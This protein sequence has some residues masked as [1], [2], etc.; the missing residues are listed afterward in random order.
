[1]SPAE[2]LEWER[3]QPGRHQRLG[4]AVYAMA[5][6]S[7]RHNLLGARLLE[8]LGTALRGG[9]CRP[10][11]SDQ[12]IHVPATG[13]Y[14]Y[15]DGIV[16]CGPVHLHGDTRDVIDNPCVVVEILSK[17]T[18]QH[19]RGEKWEGYR[20]LASLADYVLVSQRLAR[21]EHFA[22]EQDGSWRYRVFG[23]GGRFVLA[24]GAE[25]V[26]DGLYDGIFKIPN[27]N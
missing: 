23:A 1:M 5:G 4:G 7:P 12:K 8:Q 14:V 2:Y 16:I 22:R 13:D 21:L 19:D 10:F 9:P 27:N 20:G 11:S 6:G 17:S 15:A 26:V 25:L 18:E 24:S 3:A